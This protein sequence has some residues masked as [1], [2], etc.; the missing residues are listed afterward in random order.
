MKLVYLTILTCA[1]VICVSMVAESVHCSRAIAAYQEAQEAMQAAS[2]E[3]A[4]IDGGDEDA[5]A[6]EAPFVGIYYRRARELSQAR[7]DAMG[8]R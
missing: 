1:A 5:D 7:Q 4:T 3:Y 8:C 6:S 2:I